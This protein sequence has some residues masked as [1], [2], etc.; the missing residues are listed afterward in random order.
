MLSLKGYV[1]WAHYSLWFTRDG[2]VTVPWCTAVLCVLFPS[3][4]QQ[5]YSQITPYRQY[6]PFKKLK[7][8]ENI[9]VRHTKCGIHHW[10]TSKKL[11]QNIHKIWITDILI[12]RYIRKKY[13]LWFPFMQVLWN[14]S[15]NS[16]LEN[17]MPTELY[18]SVSFLYEPFWRDA[19]SQKNLNLLLDNALN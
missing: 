11:F 16:T 9:L 18:C 8:L 7:I 5:L 15:C 1:S 3:P 10:L 2:Y 4:P 6:T 13:N 17:L 14:K 19:A 12:S